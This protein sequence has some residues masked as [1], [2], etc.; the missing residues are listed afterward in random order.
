MHQTPR[1]D[2]PARD[3]W[4]RAIRQ[5]LLVPISPEGARII[6]IVVLPIGAVV[7]FFVCIPLWILTIAAGAIV[8]STLV[9]LGA[10][11]VI[12][13][14]CSILGIGGGLAL[15]FVV[16]LR[17]YRRLPAGMRGWVTPDD[18]G[19]GPRVSVPDRG[20]HAGAETA[21]APTLDDR[22]AAADASLAAGPSTADS[23]ES[24]R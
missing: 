20:F 17:I 2:P 24:R 15:S 8:G 6:D 9:A 12:G 23:H 3:G 14:I 22:I 10:P 5:L 16:L 21:V 11:D 18:E 1:H 13:T 19:E 7:A 4:K